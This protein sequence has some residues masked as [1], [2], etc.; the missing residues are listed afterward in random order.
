V[1][2]VLDANVLL[3]TLARQGTCNRVLELVLLR[4]ELVT[5][6][7]ILDDVRE[8]LVTKFRQ[9]R[10]VSSATAAFLGSVARVVRPTRLPASACRDPDDVAVLGIAVA[11]KADCIVTGDADLLVL[12]EFRGI[13]IV[14]PRAFLTLGQAAAEEE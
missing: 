1:R 11:G 3:A 8:K 9:S 6:E 2:V 14:T 12:G 4:H 5:G 7:A 10:D 13:P